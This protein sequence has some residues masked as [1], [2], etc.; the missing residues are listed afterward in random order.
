M[1]LNDRIAP[2]TRSLFLDH[3]ASDIPVEQHQI[4]IDR[5]CGRCAR[6][7]DSFLQCRQ[8]GGIISV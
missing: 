6:M 1:T 2:S 7:E 3:R 8:E 4:S 5:A